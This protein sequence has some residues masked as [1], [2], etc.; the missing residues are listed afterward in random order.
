LNAERWSTLVNMSDDDASTRD[1]VRQ[2]VNVD[3]DGVCTDARRIQEYH[4]EGF[5]ARARALVFGA[6]VADAAVASPPILS[7]LPPPLPPPVANAAPTLRSPPVAVLSGC[8]EDEDEDKAW[9]KTK[10]LPWA[11]VGSSITITGKDHSGYKLN[12][13]AKRAW[14]CNVDGCDKVLGM[15]STQ[16]DTA[17]GGSREVANPNGIGLQPPQPLGSQTPGRA[18]SGRS[19]RANFAQCARERNACSAPRF[20]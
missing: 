16:D 13:I 6:S 10:R 19:S 5:P 3:G 1:P 9:H 17:P 20:D 11:P 8:R 4:G 15:K 18:H 7:P 12:R 14:Q 2:R